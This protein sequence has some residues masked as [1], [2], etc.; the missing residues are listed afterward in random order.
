MD[1]LLHAGLNNA[2]W[3][4]AVALIAAVGARV[5][6]RH[7]AVVHALWLLVLIK[8]VTPSLVRCSIPRVDEAP[9]PPPV[10]VEP[11]DAPRRVETVQPVV[12][13]GLI[14]NPATT[15]RPSPFVRERLA[16]EPTSKA[17]ANWSWLEPTMVLWLAGAVA[18]WTL[19]VLSSLRFRRLIRAARP[20]P[21]ELV[22][23]LGQVAARLGLRR[24]PTA[25]LLPA[26]VPP[27]LW[28]PLTGPPR[29]VL[30]E[31][32][33][34]RLD[35]VQRDAVLAHELAHLKRRDHWVRRLEATVLGLYW[36]DPVAW[37]AA[38][39]SSDRRRNVATPGSSGRCRRRPGPMPRPWSRPRRMSR[40]TAEC[41]RWAPAAS[42]VLFH[43]RGG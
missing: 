42:G 10:H 30:P 9:R 32:L 26:R 4:A 40:S 2:A 3:A 35:E 12:N 37:W 28:V 20:A 8:L 16:D 1:V 27:M 11:D 41:C 19:V 34:D 6:S 18:W 24:I 23:R 39:K 22:E 25:W 38:G 14:L 17:S 7:P 21:T 33:W 31:E 36:W 5:W 13:L 43:S 29:L 15:N